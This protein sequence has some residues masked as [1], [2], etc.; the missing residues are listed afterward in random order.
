MN[1][2]KLQ[3]VAL[4]PAQTCQTRAL[5]WLTLMRNRLFLVLAHFGDLIPQNGV[6]TILRFCFTLQHELPRHH[7]SR[8]SR[9]MLF[10]KTAKCGHFMPHD[11]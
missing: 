7:A 9:R 10:T 6:V 4:S 11:I 2:E 8:E 1:P 3:P 5:S